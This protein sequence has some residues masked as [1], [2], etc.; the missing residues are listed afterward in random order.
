MPAE[1]KKCLKR[2][3]LL[4]LRIRAGILPSVWG[5]C[6]GLYIGDMDSV[7]DHAGLQD[8]PV[9]NRIIHPVDKDYTD[10]ELA[11]KFLE[12][13]DYRDIVLIGGGG[14]RIDHL[15]ANRALFSRDGRPLEWYTADEHIIFTDDDCI[16][17]C[18]KGRT[19]SFFHVQGVRL[20]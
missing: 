12:E 9:E 6:P 4:L 16:V 18:G 13:R 7:E 1:S 3:K 17:E 14:G 19:V 10:T 2:R 5:I 20:L 8:L 15:L 11:L